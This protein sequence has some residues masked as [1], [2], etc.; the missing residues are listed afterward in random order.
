[1][2]GPEGAAKTISQIP[3]LLRALVS[4]AWVALAGYAFWKFYAP[5]KA[6]VDS[7]SV[8]IEVAGFKLSFQEAA[9][10]LGKQ[11]SD[12]QSRV[13]QLEN[14]LK[15]PNLAVER[16]FKKL[17]SLEVPQSGRKMEREHPPDVYRAR[18]LRLQVLWVDDNPKGNAYI[19]GAIQSE[20]GK[21][22]TA[23]ST[24]EGLAKFESGQYDAVITDLNRREDGAY[25]G[26]AGVE[27]IRAI[28]GRNK[29]VPILVYT[30]TLQAADKEKEEEVEKAGADGITSSAVELLKLLRYPPG[31]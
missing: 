18:T 17:E 4:C 23:V 26:A 15:A 31:S 30:S 12:V 14:S 3:D 1:M 6:A 27:F 20:G 2:L 8:S 9:E 19:I 24:S 13:A 16:P 22:D 29:V 28:R 21:V 11:I 25:R 5:L 10:G 7:K